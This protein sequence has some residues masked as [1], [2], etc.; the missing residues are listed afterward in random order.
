MVFL[1]PISQIQAAV[2]YDENVSGELPSLLTRIEFDEVD[3]FTF[4]LSVGR[5]RFLGTSVGTESFLFNLPEMTYLKR[6]N[7]IYD[8]DITHNDYFISVDKINYIVENPFVISTSNL[9]YLSMA[10]PSPLV[11]SLTFI[12]EKSSITSGLHQ[13]LGGTSVSSPPEP[14]PFEIEFIVASTTEQEAH[15]IL[16]FIPAIITGAQHLKEN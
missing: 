13:F 6:I 2:I 9:E 5:N 10:M 16:D 3:D 4:N 11:Y 1:A 12:F 8:N 15:D 14:N 7:V